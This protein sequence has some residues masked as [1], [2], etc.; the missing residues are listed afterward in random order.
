VPVLM[1][2][3]LDINQFLFQ[4][5]KVIAHFVDSFIILV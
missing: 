4:L 5:C 3:R 1:K 2:A